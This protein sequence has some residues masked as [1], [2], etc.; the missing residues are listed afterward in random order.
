MAQSRGHDWQTQG[1]AQG[2]GKTVRPMR[3][4][5]LFGNLHRCYR[6]LLSQLMSPEPRGGQLSIKG[7]SPLLVKNPLLTAFV[8]FHR[9]EGCYL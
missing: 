7:G 9:L 8:T 3:T 4:Y 5:I 1:L 6:H 2:S